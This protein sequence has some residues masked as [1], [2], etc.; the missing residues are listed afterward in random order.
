M[1][2]Q[3][4]L[5]ELLKSSSSEH[6]SGQYDYEGDFEPEESASTTK[7]YAKKSERTSKRK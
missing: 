3:N 1:T 2:E 7:K 6:E 4:E 5:D